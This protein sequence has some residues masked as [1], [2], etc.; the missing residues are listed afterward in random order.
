MSIPPQ[1]KLKKYLSSAYILQ[2]NIS[3]IDW[4]DVSYNLSWCQNVMPNNFPSWYFWEQWAL[5]GS[6][7]FTKSQIILGYIVPSA[8]YN[9]SA[10]LLLKAFYN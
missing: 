1:T 9:P 3:W 5:L 6:V 10:D 8:K 2:T 4:M 7:H